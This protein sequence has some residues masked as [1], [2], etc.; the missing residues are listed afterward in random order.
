MQFTT[1]AVLANVTMQGWW[2]IVL[3]HLGSLRGWGCILQFHSTK[4]D[5]TAGRKTKKTIETESVYS[6]LVCFGS[7]DIIIV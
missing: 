1:V 6:H 3:I 5:R 4:T 2:N 7:D